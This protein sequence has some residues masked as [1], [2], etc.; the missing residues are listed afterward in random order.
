MNGKR[1]INTRE[2]ALGAMLTALGV[3]LAYIGAVTEVLDLSLCAVASLITVFSLIEFGFRYAFMIYGATA[4]L[5][6]LL[7]PNKLTA[8]IYL[9]C[10]LYSIIKANF[11]RCSTVVSWI[12]KLAYLNIIIVLGLFAAKFIFMLPDENVYTTLSLFAMGNVAFV[13][14]DIAVTRLI[15]AYL[16]VFRHRFGI[17]KYLKSVKRK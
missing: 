13:L 5:S 1:S 6:F 12:L 10:A 9:F 16:R 8:M 17:D 4:I 11:E 2:V 14:Y 15:T 7:L 3:V